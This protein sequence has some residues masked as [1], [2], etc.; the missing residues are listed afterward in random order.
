MSEHRPYYESGRLAFFLNFERDDFDTDE[1]TTP[2]D[3]AEWRRGW[4]DAKAERLSNE[5]P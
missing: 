4:D 1:F 2:K 5:R 3:I